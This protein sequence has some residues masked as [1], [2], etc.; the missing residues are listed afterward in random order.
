[1]ACKERHLIV[2]ALLALK[3]MRLVVMPRKELGKKHNYLIIIM[4]RQK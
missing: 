3:E 2:T 1:M 4:E